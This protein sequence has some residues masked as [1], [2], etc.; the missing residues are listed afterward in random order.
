MLQSIKRAVYGP[1]PKE[2]KRNCDRIVRQSVREVDKQ[3]SKLTIV[4]N[5][6]KAMI[7]QCAARNDMKSAK[8]L[9]REL[10]RSHQHKEKL[11]LSK[12]Q[13]NSIKLQVAESFAM[14]KVQGCMQSSTVVMKEVNQL[15]KV[16]EITAPMMALSQELVRTGIIEEMVTDTLDS[17]DA[18]DELELED[19][20]E[21]EVD[22][23]LNEV[24]HPP[25]R[26]RASRPV[27]PAL[28]AEEEPEEEDVDM[29]TINDMRDRLKALQS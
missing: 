8:M 25:A 18:T 29:Q 15:V 6:T 13:L 19:E 9:A 20:A 23:I 26:E 27:E 28:V 5:K 12:A 4:E 17:I 24:I 1:D 10:Y 14:Q 7:K 3:I 2:M 16:Q 11:Q 21:E 22:K